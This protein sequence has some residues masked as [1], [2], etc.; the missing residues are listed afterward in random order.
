MTMNINNAPTCTELKKNSIKIILFFRVFPRAN[1][2]KNF[3]K[4]EAIEWSPQWDCV[5]SHVVK[6]DNVTD[7]QKLQINIATKHVSRVTGWTWKLNCHGV[8]WV[9]ACNINGSVVCQTHP[10]SSFCISS[11]T[12]S[13]LESLARQFRV[14]VEWTRSSNKHLRSDSTW[15]PRFRPASSLL[16]SSNESKSRWKTLTQRN[17]DQV[18]K[19]LQDRENLWQGSFRPKLYWTFLQTHQSFGK[20][21]LDSHLKKHF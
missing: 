14:Q 13:R 8:C 5:S 15:L 9:D 19:W 16:I 6:V 4:F 17:I 18:R 21:R 7:F 3:C 20:C 2:I 11:T 1:K 10:K 12:S